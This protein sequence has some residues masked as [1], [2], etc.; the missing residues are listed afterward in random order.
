MSFELAQ[1]DKEFLI[2]ILGGKM[3]SFSWT[4]LKCAKNILQFC[5]MMSAN[6]IIFPV[7]IVRN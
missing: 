3:L 5:P 6:W 1:F 7:L 4:L 2:C